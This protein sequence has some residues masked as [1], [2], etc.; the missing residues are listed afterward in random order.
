M[1]MSHWGR[2]NGERVICGCI[3][4]SRTEK[5]KIKK[6]QLATPMGRPRHRPQTRL[7]VAGERENPQLRK[8]TAPRGTALPA[9]ARGNWRQTIPQ[10]SLCSRSAPW[11]QPTR[12]HP[13]C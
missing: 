10:A 13:Q 1:A 2:R 6:K 9:C 5:A 12:A 3:H 7:Q 11:P 8:A 4:A